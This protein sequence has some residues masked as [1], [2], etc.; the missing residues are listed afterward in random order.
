MRLSA[1]RLPPQYWRPLTL[2]VPPL[3]PN[4]FSVS[5]CSVTVVRPSVSKPCLTPPDRL[6]NVSTFSRIVS[7]TPYLSRAG[8]RP[9]HV[10]KQ[11]LA[12][13][14]QAER[15]RRSWPRLAAQK[16]RRGIATTA[17][18]GRA[19]GRVGRA[20]GVRG[21][22]APGL[23]GRLPGLVRERCSRRGLRGGIGSAKAPPARPA[24]ARAEAL[25]NAARRRRPTGR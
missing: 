6:P 2:S 9:A 8:L 18:W 21:D 10:A 14:V 1:V 19:K 17:S 24:S 23:G 20:R 12:L 13:K 25:L 4:A 15:S 16:R 22:T 7:W 11:V 3:R 5:I